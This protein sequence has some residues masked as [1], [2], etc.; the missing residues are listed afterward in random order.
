MSNSNMEIETTNAGIDGGNAIESNYE[1]RPLKECPHFT[2]EC[3]EAGTVE[4]CQE[5]TNDADQWISHNTIIEDDIWIES[6]PDNINEYLSYCLRQAGS[7]CEC[8]NDWHFK[9]NTIHLENLMLYIQ[10]HI[11]HPK[12]EW[13]N[14]GPNYQWG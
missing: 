5:C 2:I 4:H 1:R 11:H 10:S 3:I 6:A 7:Y 9:G 8:C 12:N 13:G 14:H